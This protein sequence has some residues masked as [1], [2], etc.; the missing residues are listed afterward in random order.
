MFCVV[1]FPIT[2]FAIENKGETNGSIEIVLE[3]GSEGTSKEGVLFAYCKIAN[4]ENGSYRLLEQYEKLG[5]GIN[6][7]SSSEKMEQTIRKLDK[8]EIRDG[9]VITDKAG[10]AMISSLDK[11]VYFICVPDKGNYEEVQSMVVEIPMWNEKTKNMD[12]NVRVSPKHSAREPERVI[13]GDNHSYLKY[14]GISIISLTLVVGL[15]CHNR[16]KCGKIAVNYSEEGGHTHGNDN[17]TKNPRC[18]RRVRS[19]GGRSIN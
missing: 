17:D 10:K 15:T 2:T 16:F 6:D 8:C 4:L 7:I 3:D 9:E 18:T 5:I 12:Y 13:T 1:L 11:G 14:M 19:R